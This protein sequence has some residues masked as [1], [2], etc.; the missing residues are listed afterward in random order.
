MSDLHHLFARILGEPVNRITDATSPKTLSSWNSLR[1]V[2][3]VMEIEA[4]YD[5]TFTTAEIIGLTSFAG[6]REMLQRKGALA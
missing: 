3:L 1:H 5:V 2:Q 6:V 4:S